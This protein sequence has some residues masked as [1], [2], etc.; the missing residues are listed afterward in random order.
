MR[1][2]V[3][4]SPAAGNTDA[5]S[6]DRATEV[7]R[8]HGEVEVASSGSPDELD[9]VL[10]DAADRRLVVAGGDGSLH[11][12]VAALHRRGTLA[13]QPIALVPLGTGNDFARAVDLPEDPGEA[14]L[15]AVTGRPRPLDLLADDDGGVVVNSV[16]TGAGA[17]AAQA[18]KGWKERLGKV[19]YAVGAVQAIVRPP[20]VH[21]R[22]TVDGTVLASEREPVLQVVVGNGVYVGGGAALTPDADPGDGVADV[23]VSTAVGPLARLGY[24]AGV[25]VRR[26]PRRA[27]VHTATG[28]VVSVSGRKFWCSA[29]GELT[30]PHRQKTWRVLPAAYE[31]MVP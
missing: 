18:G 8:E 30:G 31:L 16:H 3:L 27:D 19:G 20:T 12:V 17:A 7:L 4:T 2:L 1:L 11:A 28:T 13:R 24:A 9:A 15:I 25:L 22:V 23:L 6:L 26:H 21:L 14:A 10:D 5:D 29:D